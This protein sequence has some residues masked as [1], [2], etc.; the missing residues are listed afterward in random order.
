M[1]FKRGINTCVE[2][3]KK[4]K[5]NPDETGMCSKCGKQQN[6]I[7]STIYKELIDEGRFP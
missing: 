6:R 5:K 3:E 2:C 7:E 4:M 1:G